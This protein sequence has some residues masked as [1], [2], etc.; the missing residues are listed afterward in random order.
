MQ[1]TIFRLSF[2]DKSIL[3][4]KTFTKN[5]AQTQCLHLQ[6]TFFCFFYLKFFAVYSF[7]VINRCPIWTRV[8]TR[9][10]SRR[11]RRYCQP[12]TQRTV[13]YASCSVCFCL[14]LWILARSHW[15]IFLPLMLIMSGPRLALMTEERLAEVA[16]VI[17][18][19]T[20]PRHEH[21]DQYSARAC[22]QSD[23]AAVD[24]VCATV[25]VFCV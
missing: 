7:S 3:S 9:F 12:R 11:C 14:L 23:F 16:Q 1:F 22:Q 18:S 13:R 19:R 2:S 15:L 21:L 20:T 24:Q 6:K 4:A 5:D 17:P 25:R 8:A 10:G